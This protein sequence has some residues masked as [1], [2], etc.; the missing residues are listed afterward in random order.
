MDYPEI[1]PEKYCPI[2]VMFHRVK[3]GL[4]FFLRHNLINNSLIF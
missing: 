1:K 2:Q 4:E 3:I